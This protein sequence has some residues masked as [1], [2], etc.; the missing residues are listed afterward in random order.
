[1]EQIIIYARSSDLEGTD[2]WNYPQ[3]QPTVGYTEVKDGQ[4]CSL[5]VLKEEHL[6][7]KK[8]LDA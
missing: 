2:L 7:R 3:A 4:T 1:M 6:L 5:H 8:R